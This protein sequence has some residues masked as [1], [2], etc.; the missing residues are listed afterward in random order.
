MATLKLHRDGPSAWRM[1][2][3]ASDI[4]VGGI[5]Y[6]HAADGHHYRP[7][8]LV[9]GAPVELDERLSQLAMAARAVEEAIGRKL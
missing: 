9:D 8:L 1:T 2:T 3:A 5:R 6:Q 7:W 4:L